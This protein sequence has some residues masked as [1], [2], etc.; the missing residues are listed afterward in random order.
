MNDS[1]M[2][3]GSGTLDQGKNTALRRALAR[4]VGLPGGRSECL[5]DALVL[6]RD[7]KSLID[8]QPMGGNMAA[9]GAENRA[10]GS[11]EANLMLGCNVRFGVGSESF[12]TIKRGFA[13][14]TTTVVFVRLDTDPQRTSE[15]SYTTIA[16][17]DSIGIPIPLEYAVE[18]MERGVRT[19]TAGRCLED[20][21]NVDAKNWHKQ[22]TQGQLSRYDL[23]EDAFYAALCQIERW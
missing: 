3:F 20:S 5:R 7:V 17:A 4:A 14:D 16:L 2:M 6:P 18:A 23:I 11:I 21:K 13:V 10:I 9:L 15:R 12:I 22:F 19:T 1:I 8:A